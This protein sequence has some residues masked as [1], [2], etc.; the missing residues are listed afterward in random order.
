MNKFAA[1]TVALDLIRCLRPIVIALKSHDADAADQLTRAGTSVL[2]NIAEGSRREGKDRLRFYRFAHGSA[3]E[4]RAVLD[5]ADAWGWP[6]EATLAR[7]ILDRE[8]ALLW[9]LTHPKP[10]DRHARQPQGA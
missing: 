8:L 1:Y 3:N 10:R 9:G 2:N 6:N 4:I 7:E 5:G